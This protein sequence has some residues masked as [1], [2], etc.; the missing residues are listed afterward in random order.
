MRDM[1]F[2]YAPQGKTLKQFTKAAEA[3]SKG[4]DRIR[5]WGVPRNLVKHIGS[6]RKAIETVRALNDRRYIHMLG[7]SD[8]LS[9]DFLCANVLE[10]DTIDSAVP[11]RYKGV[12]NLGAVLE[13]RG[14]WWEKAEFTQ[15][16]VDNIK[17][18]RRYF[19]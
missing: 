9:D 18:A 1:P 8:D 16:M 14:D 10:V 5:Y 12:F 17:I 13:P 3:L 7:F 6:R 11:M 15:Q 2:L 4:S 19:G